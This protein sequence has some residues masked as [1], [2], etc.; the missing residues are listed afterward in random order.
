MR[1]RDCLRRPGAR[2]LGMGPGH[3]R[4]G[5]RF[6]GA[7][8]W[9][10]AAER[11]P[12]WWNAELFGPPHREM[13]MA[14]FEALREGLRLLRAVGLGHGN[15]AVA[16]GVE[17]PARRPVALATSSSA[18]SPGRLPQRHSPRG[19]SRT[20]GWL[21]AAQ[22]RSPRK[23]RRIATTARASTATSSG[24][25]VR[26]FRSAPSRR[27]SSSLRDLACRADEILKASGAY[28]AHHITHGEPW[29]AAGGSSRAGVGPA[30]STRG[31]AAPHRPVRCLIRDVTQ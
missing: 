6:R 25:E 4:A 28:V 8:P 3:R 31:A 9:T 20:T 14:L 21:L 19:Q 17:P 27:S 10:E 11:W 7:T 22:T 12:D 23:L 13:D 1:N 2:R 24:C 5:T 16:G 26:A 29:L 30:T 15:A 18:W